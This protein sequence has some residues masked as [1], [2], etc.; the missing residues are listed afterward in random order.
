MAK[1][2]QSYRGRRSAGTR[3]LIAALVIILVGACCFLLAQEYIAYTD[4]GGMYLDLPFGRIDLP[5]PP[6][7]AEPPEDEP[8]ADGTEDSQEPAPPDTPAA[9][10]VASSLPACSSFSVTSRLSRAP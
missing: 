8:P 9:G 6:P 1:G 7:A 2:Y 10:P 4:D 3:L 5:K